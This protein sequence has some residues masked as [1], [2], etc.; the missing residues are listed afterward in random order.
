MKRCC[1]TIQGEVVFIDNKK[2]VVVPLLRELDRSLLFV[3]F[4][5][6]MKKREFHTM[7]AI[8]NGPAG[9]CCPTQDAT[10]EGQDY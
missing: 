9:H 1:K 10:R 2:A 3:V 7:I 5:A 4:L 6:E 8:S